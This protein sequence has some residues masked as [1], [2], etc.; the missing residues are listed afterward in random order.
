MSA[1][2]EATIDAYEQ[3]WNRMDFVAMAALWD[4]AE[5][6]IYYAAEEIDHS[7]HRFEDVQ[8]YWQRTAAVVESVCLV[9]A[10]RRFKA[11]TPTLTIATF[12]MHV[13][14]TMRGFAEQAVK[15]VGADARVSTILRKRSGVW[16][17]IHY[18]EA[19]LG[20]LPFIRRAYNANVRD[21]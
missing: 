9:T 16:R 1:T 17:F 8:D 21:A 5:G 10:N 3:A 12:D 4:S 19:T 7:M 11:L 14:I 20:A 6:D 2:P 15:P 18:A 13:D